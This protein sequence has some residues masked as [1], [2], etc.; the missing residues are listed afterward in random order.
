VCFKK[1]NSAKK[2]LKWQK[3]QAEDAAKKEAERQARLKQGTETINALFDGAPVMGERDAT[4]DW[5]QFTTK[6]N[7]GGA[8]TTTP[9]KPSFRVSGN[10][11]LRDA[12]GYGSGQNS[13]YS[14]NPTVQAK[15]GGRKFTG[16]VPEGYTA[17]RVNGQWVL[18]G[19]DGKT[20]KKGDTVGYKEKYDTGQKT[21]GFGDDFYNKYRSATLGYYE[22]ELA[23]QYDKARSNLTYDHA[24]AGT[25]QSSMAGDNLADL[26]YQN[27]NNLA[28][29][30]SK[31]DA[32][33]GQ[34]KTS[35]AGQKAAALGQL[36][37][38][39]DPGIAANVATNSVRNLQ[40]TTPEFEPMGQ[41]FNSA[42][43]GATNYAGAYNDYK[44]WGSPS[45]NSKGSG[46]TIG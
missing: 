13:S 8:G 37:A 40:S 32:A 38:T 44:N 30:R 10:G 29:I 19:P 26:L 11:D 36:Y 12:G 16:T 14:K 3:K 31:A 17:K 9:A 1:D 46:R 2:A 39:E 22:P 27:T 25:L 23:K 21:G 34:L 6:A 42:V 41:L 33:T 4:Y 45:G 28:M 5:S 15:G 18:V 43:V 35:V 20:Y 7:G 24:R